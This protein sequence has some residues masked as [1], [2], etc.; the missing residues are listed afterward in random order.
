[1]CGLHH[2]GYY[3]WQDLLVHNKGCCNANVYIPH[4]GGCCETNGPLPA[5]PCD[6]MQLPQHACRLAMTNLC[7]SAGEAHSQHVTGCIGLPSLFKGDPLH[8]HMSS[9]ACR[10]TFWNNMLLASWYFLSVRVAD[11]H[12]SLHASSRTPPV[13]CMYVLDLSMSCTSWAHAYF[14]TCSR[15]AANQP[16][17]H[18][19]V[20]LHG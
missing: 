14:L 18:C 8:Q 19:L 3:L 16:F 17:S 1:M 5:A 20:W 11:C 9:P 7:S 6:Q 13:H 4:N 2:I 10:H 15:P 12:V